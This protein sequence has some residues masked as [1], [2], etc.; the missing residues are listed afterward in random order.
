MTMTFYSIGDTVLVPAKII[1]I[2]INDRNR[3]KYVASLPDQVTNDLP[4][5]RWVEFEEESRDKIVLKHEK[6]TSDGQE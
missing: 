5:S 3:V 4:C 6:E 2:T 1:K